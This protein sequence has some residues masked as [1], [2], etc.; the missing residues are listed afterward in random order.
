MLSPTAAARLRT[1]LTAL[2]EL[3][4]YA[5]LDLTPAS[6]T[7]YGTI[8]TGRTH[9]PSPVN[10][11]VLSLLGPGDYLD[12]DDPDGDQAGDMPAA[13]VL[14][15]WAHVVTGRYHRKISSACTVLLERWPATTGN[16]WSAQLAEDVG[17][18]HHT[19]E[20][21]AHLHTHRRT[22]SLPCPA[23]GLLA[24]AAVSGRD[25]ECSNC[26]ATMA[27]ADYDRRADSYADKIGA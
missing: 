24:L 3:C 16:T 1:Q 19:L 7:R 15:A 5:W 26:G 14:C 11:Q 17:R 25:V 12:R 22:L 21:V 18:L 4:A 8:H 23:C 13:A 27:A 6:S 10:E 2:P 20:N 9:A